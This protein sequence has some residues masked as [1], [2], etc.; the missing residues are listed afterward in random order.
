M[1]HRISLEPGATSPA[2]TARFFAE[3]AALWRKVIT[4]AGIQPQ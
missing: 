2:E 4:E 3:E 1:L